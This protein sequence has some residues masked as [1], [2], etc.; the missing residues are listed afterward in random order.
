V[1]LVGRLYK[2]ACGTM[3]VPLMNS[4]PNVTCTLQPFGLVFSVIELLSR[5]RCGANLQERNE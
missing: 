3:S 4:R 2:G 5:G 1:G